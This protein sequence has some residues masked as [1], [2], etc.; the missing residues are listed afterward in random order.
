LFGDVG[1][2]WCCEP[3]DECDAGAL[4]CIALLL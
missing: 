1:R 3:V 4:G 2:F